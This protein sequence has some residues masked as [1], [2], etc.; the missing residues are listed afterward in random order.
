MPA[1]V[2]PRPDGDTIVNP[3]LYAAA[4][5]AGEYT[6]LVRVVQAARL[7]RIGLVAVRASRQRRGIARALLAQVL[8][9]LHEAGIPTATAEVNEANTAATALFEGLGARRASSNLELVRHG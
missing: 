5:E 8:G 6:G 1:E 7:P 9:A 4:A 2:L 3:A